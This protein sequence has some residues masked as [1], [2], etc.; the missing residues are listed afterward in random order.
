MLQNCELAFEL[1][2]DMEQMFARGVLWS[3]HAIDDSS[4]DTMPGVVSSSNLSAFRAR[5]RLDASRFG[6]N[7]LKLEN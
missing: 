6:P 5:S 4:S 2:A 1:M 7:G 3:L